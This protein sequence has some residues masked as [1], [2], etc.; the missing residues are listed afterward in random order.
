MNQFDY[1]GTYRRNLPHIQPPEATLFVTFRLDG[2]LPAPVLERWRVEKKQLEM[3]L[4][5]WAAM[6]PPGT[7]P[8]PDE[9]AQ[10]KL[11]FH[12]RWFKKFEAALDGATTGPLWLKDERLAAIVAESLHHRDGSIYRL[13]AFCIMPNHV[14]VVFAPLLT[15]ALAAELVDKAIQHRR[16]ALNETLPADANDE[17]CEVVLASIMGSLKGWT[18]RRCNEALGRQGQFWQHE[19][20]DHV[21]RHQAEQARVVKYVIDNPVKAKLVEHWQDWPW[22][23]QRATAAVAQSAEIAPLDESQP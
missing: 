11:K 18:A 21:I 16:A 1:K 5:R 2:S 6:A 22:S 14:H 23:Y 8:D 4:L 20:F 7:R 9:V 15:E 3:T 12:R 19:S 10:E 13:D 17:I